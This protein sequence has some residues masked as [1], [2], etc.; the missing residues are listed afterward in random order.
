MIEVIESAFDKLEQGVREGVFPGAVACVGNKEGIIYSRNCGY[1]QLYPLREEMELDTLFDIAS[2]TKVTA[3]L[4]LLMVF[5]QKGN[6]SLYDAVGDYLKAFENEKELKIKHLLTHTSGFE[7]Y[8]RMDQKGIKLED[9][10]SYIAGTKRMFPIGKEVVYSDYNFI[11]LKF[12]LEE[13]VQESFEEACRKYV[14][15]PLEMKNTIF[16]PQQSDNIAAT[17][18]CEERK[19]FLKGVVHDENARYFGG[20]S[21]HAGL[22]S[23][24]EDLSKYCEMYL[25]NGRTASGD[26]FFSPTTINGIIHNY[27]RGLQE[28][29]GLGFCVRGLENSSGGE[30]FSEEAFGHT[31]FTGTSIWID[32]VRGIY[33]IL[34]TNRVHPNR[35]NTEII[36]FRR[37]FHN[38][39]NYAVDQGFTYKSLQRD[40]RRLE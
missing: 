2:L 39:V 33:I 26:L 20:V 9:I 5:L 22:F 18:F 3:T 17:E 6:L 1:R 24:L 4:P 27:T 14:F 34:L 16:N 28:N 29:R 15:N 32:R 19:E 13:I 40:S 11:L 36:K 30:L 38:A 7:P 23:N 35:E 31:G 8:S 25:N 21:G 37:H 10:T 12:I